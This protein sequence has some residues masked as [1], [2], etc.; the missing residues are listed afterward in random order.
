MVV[1][2]KSLWYQV[3]PDSILS[4][5]FNVDLILQL[6]MIETIPFDWNDNFWTNL[7]QKTN[8]WRILVVLRCLWRYKL[9]MSFDEINTLFF[10]NI[11]MFFRYIFRS[12]RYLLS[13]ENHRVVEADCRTKE[14]FVKNWIWPKL[15][16]YN[17][18]STR[19]NGWY[20]WTNYNW[21]WQYLLPSAHDIT[22]E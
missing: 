12:Q 2:P 20:T 22:I 14:K 18:N 10:T 9:F 1:S 17:Q 6:N 4:L 7:K 3:F 8:I 13:Y 11:Q 19:L 16:E 5:K 15:D 21:S